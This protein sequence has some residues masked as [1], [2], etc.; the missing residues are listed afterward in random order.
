MTVKDNDKGWKKLV[1][2]MAKA[3]GQHVRIGVQGAKASE[4]HEAYGAI[5]NGELAVIL[6]FGTA[7]GHIPARP[8]ITGT[9]EANRKIL[10]NEVAEDLKAD[11]NPKRALERAGLLAV[12][13][14]RSAITGGSGIPP[15][16]AP[17]TIRAKGSSRP[18]VDTGRYLN[19]ID[20]QYYDKA[21]K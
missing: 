18:L 14:I 6:E 12:N 11:I 1:E 9:F 8:A 2:K 7:D 5:T 4:R 17:S 19:S 3:H 15:P 21:E 10:A 16:N 13:Q 20:Y